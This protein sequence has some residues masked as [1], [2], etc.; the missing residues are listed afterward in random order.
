[1][2]AIILAGGL[3]T[4]LK[5]IT[6][7]KP[8]PMADI[9]GKPF[10]ECLLDFLVAQGVRSV[11]LAVGYKAEFIQAYF[12]GEF[13]GV[14][15]LYSVENSPLGTGGALKK[16]LQKCDENDVLIFNGD[17]FFDINLREF[18]E[19]ADK[20]SKILIALKMMEN[21]DR[22]GQVELDAKGFITGFKEKRQC[23]KGLINGGIY[24]VKKDIFCEFFDEKASLFDKV[25]SAN[26]FGF[27]FNKLGANSANALDFN[28]T[29]A[30][31]E[32]SFSFEDFLQEHFKALKARG[33]IFDGYFK[34]IG[35]I[36]DYEQFKKD[37][38]NNIISF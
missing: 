19:K 23:E 7:D 2:Q 6:K 35:I 9:N 3:G 26:E 10:L 37:A 8:K 34:D 20:K 12:K 33:E 17:S 22:Y 30:P 4:R 5:A 29:N 18:C 38:K 27:G 11:V 25:S 32:A 31:C 15:I 14:K 16:A 28:P 13:K 24:L 1:M 36:G 21:F